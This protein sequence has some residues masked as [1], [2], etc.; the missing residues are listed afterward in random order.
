MEFLKARG[1]SPEPGS[2]V[3]EAKPEP[4]S[5]ASPG[6][7]QRSGKTLSASTLIHSSS[8]FDPL[9]QKFRWRTEDKYQTACKPGSVHLCP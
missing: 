3:G 8:I 2:W 5:T 4:A 7:R 1:N 9:D 6:W